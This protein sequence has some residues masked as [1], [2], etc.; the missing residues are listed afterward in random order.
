MKEAMADPSRIEALTRWRQCLDQAGWL[1]SCRQEDCQIIDALGRVIAE[2]VFASR[3]VP[4]YVGAAM[5]GFAVRA[6]DTT[7]LLPGEGRSLPVLPPGS[8]WR[9]QT[10]VIVDTGDALPDGTDSV[11]MKEHVVF[12]AQQIE[13][14]SSVSP[15]QHVRKVGEDMLQGQLVLPAERVVSPA[16]IAACLAV[17]ADQVRVFA[18]P[19]VCVIPTGSEIVDSADELPPGS[20]RDI[21]SYM[22]AALFGNWG[23]V[24][25]RHPVVADDREGLRQAIAKVLPENDLVVINAGTSGGTE[26][27]TAT[28]LAGL[29]RVCCHGVAIRPGRPVILAVVQGKPVLG[30]PGYPVSCMLT[31]ELFTQELLHEFQRKPLPRRQTVQARLS[32]AV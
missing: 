24:V 30:L 12:D 22:L 5:D 7:G 14:R 32:R 26:D 29:G 8:P 19:K 18:R 25:R 31:A 16:D 9:P 1:A 4:H 20:I 2:P 28:V 23:A 13:F 27:F 6:H 10:A 17:A 3:S 15:G 21:N 11:I